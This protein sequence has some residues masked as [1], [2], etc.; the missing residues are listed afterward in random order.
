MVWTT[1]ATP[2]SGTAI[3]VAFW[4]V[5]G[6]DNLNYLRGL[7]PDA[8]G[9]DYVLASN[10]ASS[11]QFK[12]ITGAMITDATIDIAKLIEPINFTQ[13][14]TY[15]GN[16]IWDDNNLPLTSIARLNSA[17]NFTT[18]PTYLS[19]PLAYVDLSNAMSI[20]AL[21]LSGALSAG[22]VGGGNL[23]G[24][25][26]SVLGLSVGANGVDAAGPV[27]GTSLQATTGNATVAGAVNPGSYTGGT[28]G[29]GVP[30]VKGIAVG[31][32]GV[33]AAGPVSGTSIAATA[34]NVTA[35][36]AVNPGSYTGGSASV[37]VPA[38]LGLTV[39]TSGIG[40]A[41]AISIAGSQ[42]YW[43]GNPPPV[44]GGAG[45]PSGLIGAFETAAAIA[46]GWARYTA[47]DGRMLVGAGTTFS[48]TFV[49]AT[50]YGS[51][52]SFTPSGSVTI[53]I[54]SHSTTRRNANIA[55]GAGSDNVEDDHSHGIT[56]QTF[57][58][59]STT[60]AIPSRAVVWAQKT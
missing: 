24:G 5:N 41:G 7:L 46:T 43:P 54:A 34:G 22:Q 15:L 32:N 13:Q 33:D 48:T 12:R 38:V 14:P 60:W 8:P 4:N 18:R 57:T 6:R 45:V 47:A 25:I 36:G 50:N 51:A 27:K 11:G 23:L 58:G 35:A 42:V 29:T 17:S 39:G 49:E 2:I 28:T 16:L 31:V 21:T 3:T 40:S 30:S 59:A 1:P 10:N 9:A 37:G 53:V 20:A 56:S 19:N 55:F 52:W 26:L 44:S